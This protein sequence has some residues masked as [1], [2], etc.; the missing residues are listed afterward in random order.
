MNAIYLKSLLAGTA[1][2]SIGLTAEAQTTQSSNQLAG[3]SDSYNLGEDSIIHFAGYFDT[4]YTIPEGNGDDVFAIKLAPIVHYQYRNRLFFEA[5]GEFDFKDDGVSEKSSAL[6]Y[7]MLNILVNDNLSIGVGKYLSPVGQFVQNLHPSW[8]NKLPSMPIGFSSGHHG[9]GAAPNN[10]FGIQARGGFKTSEQGRL[11]YALFAGNGPELIVE[12]AEDGDLFI[13]GITLPAKIDDAN[14]DKATGFRLGFLPI[15][16]LE[17]GFS[18]ERADAAFT[19]IIEA[20]RDD[21]HIE[22]E[23]LEHDDEAEEHTEDEGDDH[24]EEEDNHVDPFVRDRDYQVWSVDFYYA[25]KQVRNLVFR[26]EFVSTKLGA[27]QKEEADHDLKR[28][29]AWYGQASYFMADTKLE[30]VTRYGNFQPNGEAKIKQWSVGLNYLLKSNSVIKAAYEFNDSGGND[31][32]LFQYA[33][34]F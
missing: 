13:E 30:A 10:D 14:S 16:N 27:G 9:A 6:E 8:I 26:G 20:H 23:D 21:G 33:Y 31:R 18:F 11:N 2:I 4:G 29:E 19:S 3:V 22:E 25:P 17:I 7:A 12:E 24:G 1:V 15:P 32:L 34:G 28:W 5:E